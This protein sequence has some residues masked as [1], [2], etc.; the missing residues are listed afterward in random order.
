[1]QSAARADATS[2]GLNLVFRN[3]VTFEAVLKQVL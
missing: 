1:M 3:I 2:D